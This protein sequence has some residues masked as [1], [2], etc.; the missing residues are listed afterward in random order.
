MKV[1]VPLFIAKIEVCYGSLMATQIRGPAV[2]LG[3]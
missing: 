2:A 1:C 3:S